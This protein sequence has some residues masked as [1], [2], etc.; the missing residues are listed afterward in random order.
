MNH[1]EQQPI[2]ET[3]EST[4]NALG[5]IAMNSVDDMHVPSMDEQVPRS[6]SLHLS[7]VDTI[8]IIKL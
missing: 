6:W 8:P 3:S 5:S 1:K 7:G 2:S 4:N